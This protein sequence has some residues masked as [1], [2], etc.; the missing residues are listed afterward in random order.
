MVTSSNGWKI[1]EW[2][3]K[4]QTNKQTNNQTKQNKQNKQNKQTKQNKT[5]QN[6]QTKPHTLVF[7]NTW[8]PSTTFNGLYCTE[9]KKLWLQILLLFLCQTESECKWDKYRK[10]LRQELRVDY[11]CLLKCIILVH[12]YLK[13]IWAFPNS[14]CVLTVCKVISSRESLGQF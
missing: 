13:F 8:F 14:C 2:D 7:L 9:L 4:Y 3:E 12:L 10:T 1:L 6:K 5:K 11:G